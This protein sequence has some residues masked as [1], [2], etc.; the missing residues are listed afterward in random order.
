MIQ[1][2][3][4]PALEARIADQAHARG[5]A[6]EQYIVETLEA[7]APFIAPDPQAVEQAIENIRF[8]RQEYAAQHDDA[9][10]EMSQFAARHGFIHGE[11]EIRTTAHEGHKY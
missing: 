11:E 7:S 10:E 5:L 2:D 3:L 8:L 4:Q 1:I 6:L 9:I